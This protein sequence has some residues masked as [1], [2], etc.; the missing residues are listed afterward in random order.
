MSF[1]NKIN[2]IN[3]NRKIVRERERERERG[4]KRGKEGFGHENVDKTWSE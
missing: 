4:R 2:L 1:V 3:Q